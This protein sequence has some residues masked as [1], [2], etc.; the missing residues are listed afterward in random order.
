MAKKMEEQNMIKRAQNC[1]QPENAVEATTHD[2]IRNMTSKAMSALKSKGT[3]ITITEK[4]DSLE[5]D[6]D[7][8]KTS[9]SSE[10]DEIKELE[11]RTGLM[12][13]PTIRRSFSKKFNSF[14]S[15]LGKSSRKL[16]QLRSVNFDDQLLKN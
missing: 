4:D 13:S 14:N 2:L 16:M 3:T 9:E 7:S 8:L 12:K 5:R 6:K 11:V 1:E 15:S 10:I